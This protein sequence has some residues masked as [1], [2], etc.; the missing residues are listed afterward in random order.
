[1]NFIFK[2]VSDREAYSSRQSAGGASRS[3]G[4][5]AYSSRK[6]SAGGA[7]RNEQE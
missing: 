1:M 7:N 2:F 4:R 5:E 3:S 6:Q